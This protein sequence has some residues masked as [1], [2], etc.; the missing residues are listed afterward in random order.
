[1]PARRVY[2][3]YNVARPHLQ[4][5]DCLSYHSPRWRDLSARL[6]TI[7]RPGA[8][9]TG[10]VAKIGGRTVALGM[11]LAAQKI[12][13]LSAEVQRFPGRIDVYR[14]AT[15]IDE[16]TID[17]DAAQIIRG[18]ACYTSHRQAIAGEML[19]LALADHYGWSNVAR[20]SLFYL[21][22]A[23]FFARPSCSDIDER[24]RPPFCSQAYAYAVRKNFADLVREC[25]DF[26]CLPG[27]IIRS[28]LLTYLFTLDRP[29]LDARP[30]ETYLEAAA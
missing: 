26:D 8:F 7:A 19:D 10:C 25:P 11:R 18:R 2:V 29:T 17:A 21:P 15:F 14:L 6:I 4:D 3:P 1:M 5:A 9:H 23:R 22:L 16:T 13:P 30:I 27:D 20:S 24:R 28:P 12:L